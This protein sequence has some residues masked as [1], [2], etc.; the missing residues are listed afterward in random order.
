MW[1]HVINMALTNAKAIERYA[2]G[3]FFDCVP[4]LIEAWRT[5]AIIP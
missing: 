4:P 2:V 3:R 5:A 1:L